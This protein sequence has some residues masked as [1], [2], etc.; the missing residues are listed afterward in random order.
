M[1][2]SGTGGKDDACVEE[3]D[4]GLVALRLSLATADGRSVSW[5]NEVLP[6]SV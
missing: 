6:E 4:D 5:I 3:S 1:L 2:L